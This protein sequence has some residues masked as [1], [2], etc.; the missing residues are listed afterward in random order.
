MRYLKFFEISP[1]RRPNRWF[2]AGWEAHLF[3]SCPNA[4]GGWA[5]GK[6]RQG[7]TGLDLAGECGTPLCFRDSAGSAR[8]R[9]AL[10]AAAPRSSYSE[11]IPIVPSH[12]STN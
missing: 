8:T 5:E 6:P 10:A 3:I 4:P 1:W 2:G 9:R 11:V 12:V 7:Q